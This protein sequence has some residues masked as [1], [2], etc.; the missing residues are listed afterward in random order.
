[1]SAP[2]AQLSRKAVIVTTVAAIVVGTLIMFGAVLPAEFNKDPLGLGKLTGLDRLW[3][4]AEVAYHAPA[5]AA[6]IAREY[7][8]GWRTDVVE[9]P[10]RASN[11][12]LRG[13]ELEYKVRMKAG[14]ALIYEWAVVG[15][16]KPEEFFTDFHG[17][18]LSGGA[19]ETVASYREATGTAANGALT[20]PFDGVHGWYVQN[21]STQDVIVRIKIAGFYDLVP[22]Y[23]AGNEAGLIANVPAAEAFGVLE[24]ND[25]EKGPKEQV[26]KPA[27]L[28]DLLRKDAANKRGLLGH[29]VVADGQ[30]TEGHGVA[31]KRRVF[32][33]LAE[34]G[35]AFFQVLDTI[36]RCEGARSNNDHR[37][38]PATQP[39]YSAGCL[40][41]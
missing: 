15:N 27:R 21:R 11:H 7:A 6:P 13:S 24:Q 3:A 8:A 28:S 31:F 39:A 33:L 36:G 37:W 2:N 14:A 38:G 9:I 41:D 5:D 26:G 25:A 18:T 30:F 17:H 10:L 35:G 20:A 34:V 19:E 29:G 22:Q 4:P 23:E 1:M 32:R 12:R 40:I 16:L